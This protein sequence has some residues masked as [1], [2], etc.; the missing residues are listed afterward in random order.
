MR[1]TSPKREPEKL[2]MP[3]APLLMTVRRPARSSKSRSAARQVWVEANT[4]TCAA[5]RTASSS[6]A[7]RGLVQRIMR[8]R[9]AGERG[10]VAVHDADAQSADLRDEMHRQRG[11][12][13]GRAAGAFRAVRRSSI[14]I[15]F[16]RRT[17]SSPTEA[18]IGAAAAGA[19]VGGA[20]DLGLHIAADGAVARDALL[21]LGEPVGLGVEPV[22]VAV[23]DDR[24]LPRRAASRSTSSSAARLP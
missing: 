18:R 1:E 11:Q 16:E 10:R 7:R 20:R 13:L 23:E 9:P 4:S 15:S 5:R 6:R 19:D 3:A 22:E 2:G 8:E 24:A 21:D 12:S 14:R 17:T